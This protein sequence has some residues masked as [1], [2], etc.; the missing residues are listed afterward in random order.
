MSSSASTDTFPALPAD[1]AEVRRAAGITIAPEAALHRALQERTDELERVRESARAESLM[2]RRRVS[3]MEDENEDNRR[4]RAQAVETMECREAEREVI[5]AGLRQQIDTLRRERDEAREAARVDGPVFVSGR[6]E[7]WSDIAAKLRAILDPAD[8]EHLNL[9]GL[10]CRVAHLAAERA[11][12]DAW[13]KDA[14]PT[15]PDVLTPAEARAV[16]AVRER[17]RLDAALRE[18]AETINEHDDSADLFD[19]EE[20]SL[21]SVRAVVEEFLR[22]HGHPVADERATRRFAPPTA[23]DVGPTTSAP[24]AGAADPPR[25]PPE[26]SERVIA[27]SRTVFGEEP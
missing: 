9:D 6:H 8:T 17:D 14:P 1:V 10:L 21:A 2:L 24:A 4:R 13:A 5:E 27:W 12:W 3:E 7:G 15:A 19:S 22:A 20:E 26:P 23:P 11:A 25:P 16:E 18:L